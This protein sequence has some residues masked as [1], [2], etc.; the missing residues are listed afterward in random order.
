M[1]KPVGCAGRFGVAV[2]A[3]ASFAAPLPAAAAITPTSDPFVVMNSASMQAGPVP[4]G[5]R[6]SIVTADPLTLEVPRVFTR[7]TQ[8]TPAGTYVEATCGADGSLLRLPILAVD[9]VGEGTRIDVYYPNSVG[10][11][12]FGTC[13]D[14]GTSE[15]KVHPY[16]GAPMTVEVETVPAHPGIFT[17]GD[18]PDGDHLDDFG[19]VTTPIV[20]CNER[21]PAEP[22]VCPVR[23][24]GE[25][26]V[27]RITLTG[28]DVLACDPCPTGS[29][30]FELARV[31]EGVPGPFVQ[32][33]L[34]SLVRD[35]SGIE[36]AKIYMYTDMLPGVYQLRVRN[37]LRPE[38]PPVLRVE[39]GL[40][41]G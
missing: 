23:V 3:V 32:Q 14:S 35:G 18:A 5:A 36:R 29:I 20:S 7:W 12:P 2:L 38:F 39:F 9:Q 15:F 1:I 16:G 24:F 31:T 34:G 22:A 28:S 17:V 21:L 37:L 33:I 26:A 13:A 41:V 6:L 4:R 25:P 8:N 40:P 11:E 19:G 10:S 30:V 27:L